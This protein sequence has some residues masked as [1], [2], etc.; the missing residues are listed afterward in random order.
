M[1]SVSSVAVPERVMVQGGWPGTVAVALTEKAMLLPLIVPLAEP[2]ISMV[3]KQVALNVPEPVVPVNDETV[4]LKFVHDCAR[5]APGAC[6]TVTHVP[7]SID[8]ELL[9]VVTVLL[10][11]KQPALSRAADATTARIRFMFELAF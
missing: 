7:P 8:D 4:H 3:P 10:D 5:P 11:L 2:A 6:A 1:R 9:G